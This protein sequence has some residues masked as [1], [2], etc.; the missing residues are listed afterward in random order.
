[1]NIGPLDLVQLIKEIIY[2]SFPFQFSAL[3]IYAIDGCGT[4]NETRH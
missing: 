2:S 3:A 4:S 1:M